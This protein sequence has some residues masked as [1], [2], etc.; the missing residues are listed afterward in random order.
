MLRVRRCRPLTEIAG[1]AWQVGRVRGLDASMPSGRP[2]GLR[3]LE[4]AAPEHSEQVHV[5]R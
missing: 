5:F 4:L 3:R 1:L 2:C